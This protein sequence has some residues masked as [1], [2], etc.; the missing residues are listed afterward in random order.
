MSQSQAKPSQGTTRQPSQLASQPAKHRCWAYIL[1]NVHINTESLVDRAERAGCACAPRAR[2]HIHAHSSSAYTPS[3]FQRLQTVE[4]QTMQIEQYF[5]TKHK[6]LSISNRDN[7]ARQFRSPMHILP[8]ILFFCCPSFAIK[9]NTAASNGALCLARARNRSITMHA[10]AKKFLSSGQ[11]IKSSRWKWNNKKKKKKKT[12]TTTKMKMK[13]QQSHNSK[14]FATMKL[15][16]Y[17]WEYQCLTRF[18]LSFFLLQLRLFHIA[19]FLTSF[20]LLTGSNYV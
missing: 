8:Y 14:H 20:E 12:A 9:Y 3:S 19:S 15:S 4:T 17:E 16:V 7:S 1:T 6:I 13:R 5:V 2:A 11:G 10:C 18:S